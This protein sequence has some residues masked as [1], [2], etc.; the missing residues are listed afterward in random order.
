METAWD[1]GY[2]AL[3]AIKGGLM[4]Y[5]IGLPYGNNDL[6]MHT[7]DIPTSGAYFLFRWPR[8]QTP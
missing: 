7:T 4:G 6:A 3:N 2:R 8:L 1:A 5:V